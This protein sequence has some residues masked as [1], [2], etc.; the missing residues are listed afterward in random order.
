MQTRISGKIRPPLH[1]L[2][3]LDLFDSLKAMAK[4]WSLGYWSGS[5]NNIQ[6]QFITP[7]PHLVALVKQVLVEAEFG[8][9]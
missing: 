8:W 7:Y 3:V 5:M 1:I 9:F 2:Q 6:F 4:A